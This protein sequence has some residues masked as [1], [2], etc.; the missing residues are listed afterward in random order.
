MALV[1]V[2]KHS[3][4]TSINLLYEE[5]SAMTF[6]G[7]SSGERSEMFGVSCAMNGFE[8]RKGGNRNDAEGMCKG[9]VC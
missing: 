6:L 7:F 9:G 2:S 3:L 1:L 4:M 5:S 8:G